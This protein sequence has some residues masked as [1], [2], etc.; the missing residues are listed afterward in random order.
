MAYQPKSYRKFLAT[1][2]TAAMVATVATPFASV[3]AA[4]N[5]KDVNASAW[6]AKNVDYLVGKDVLKG[7]EDGTFKPN[8]GVT[9]AEAAKMIVAAL[10]YELPA[11]AELKF[12]DTKNDA[13]YAAYVQVLVEKGIVEGN[14]DGTF[15]P[16]AVITR[17][18]LAKM[19]VKAYELEGNAGANVSFPDVASG[20]WYTNDILALASLGVVQGKSNGKFEPNATVTRAEAAAFLHRTEVP[21]ERVDVNNG[22]FAVTGVTATNATTLTVKGTALAGLKAEDIT[23][24]GNTVSSVTVAEDG[25]SATVKLANP[26]VHDTTTKVTVNGKEFE[27]SYKIEATGVKIAEGQFF[28]DDTEKQFIKILVDG[29]GVTAQELITAGY[30]VEFEAFDKR[31]GGAAVNIF[32]DNANTSTT[33]ELK[34]DLT[35]ELGTNASKDYYVT[36]TLTR[37]SDVMVSPST[38]ITVKNLDSAADSITNS[39][40]EVKSNATFNSTFT[41]ASS[42]LAAGDT[43]KFTEL[44][45]SVGGKKEV[46]KL[47]ELGSMYSVKSSDESVISVDKST[48]E[49]T[50]EGPGSATITV[51]YGGATYT[52]T[53]TVK[54]EKRKIATAKL[55]KTSVNVGKNTAPGNFK[56]QIVDQYGDPVNVTAETHFTV[57][58]SDETVAKGVIDPVPSIDG[59]LEYTVTVDGVDTGTADFIIRNEAGTR[60]GP[61]VRV[62]VT[63]NVTISKYTLTVD[64][65]ISGGDVTKVKDAGGTDATKN[66]I[67]TDATIDTGDEK[68]VKIDVKAFNSANQELP[69][70]K[71]GTDFDVTAINASDSDVLAEGFGN[72]LESK[73]VFQEDD[74]L[75]V[76]AGSNDGTVTITITDKNNS[77]VKQTIKLTV[78]D[79]GVAVT[80]VAFKNVPTVNYATTLNYEDFLSYTKAGGT[81]DPR[82]SGLT[83]SRTYTQAVRL[84][85]GV[86]AGVTTNLSNVDA[87]YIDL[88]GDGTHTDGEPIVGYVGMATT[89]DVYVGENVNTTAVAATT[90]YAVES[91]SDGNVIFR[92]YNDKGEMVATKVVKV[93]F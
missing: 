71:A 81:A 12:K 51:T 40:I 36:V 82:I 14:P 73:G 88:N 67:S 39:V 83:L 5:F 34:D 11:K 86:P 3:E 47:E 17:A 56:V 32:R 43:A 25:K 50:A 87:L 26:I 49:L 60:I 2:V 37:G 64:N 76:K 89:G 38:K 27:V 92:V 7:Y 69:A 21:A 42:T 28:D 72:I 57:H 6:Y 55:N 79:K 18:A 62:N 1:T 80:K 19:V 41:L 53:L 20:A 70:P 90:G 45:A 63:E 85:T 10:D 15:A 35:G 68:Y 84:N 77:N 48:Y 29:K 33:G 31:N 74:Y 58:S 54:S 44:H 13:W 93:D 16:N 91:G 4:N 52:K 59:R 9:R 65:A 30:T 46:V 8:N 75:I 22:K 66:N 61:S 24:E 23:V 78:T